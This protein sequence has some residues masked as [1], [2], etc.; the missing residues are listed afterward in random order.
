MPGLRRTMDD[1]FALGDV[2]HPILGNVGAG[3]EIAFDGWI[4]LSRRMA[5]SITSVTSFDSPRGVVDRAWACWLVRR[6]ALASGAAIWRGADGRPHRGDLCRG[7]D[8]RS[9]CR[10]SGPRRGS[11]GRVIAVM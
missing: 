5:T 2:E 6:R 1:E 8:P 9:P 10:P 4:E 11:Y 3:I 7:L